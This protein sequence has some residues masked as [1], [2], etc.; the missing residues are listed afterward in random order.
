MEERW[1]PS[2]NDLSFQN[3]N[4]SPFPSSKVKDLRNKQ[5]K[6][7]TSDFVFFEARVLNF[8]SPKVN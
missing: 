2:G 5:G 1:L 6:Y 7:L 3:L 8:F 4:T